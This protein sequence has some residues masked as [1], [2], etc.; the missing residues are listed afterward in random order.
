MAPVRRRIP[1]IAPESGRRR[2]GEPEQNAP[3]GGA[4]PAGRAS[5]GPV[6]R[7]GVGKMTEH[8]PSHSVSTSRTQGRRR[9][10]TNPPHRPAQH[11]DPLVTTRILKRSGC[12]GSGPSAIRVRSIPG[13][14]APHRRVG[15]KAL[16]A[17]HHCGLG[18]LATPMRDP[19]PYPCPKTSLVHFQGKTDQSSRRSDCH[20]NCEVAIGDVMTLPSSSKGHPGDLVCSSSTYNAR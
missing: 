18:A 17:G 16:P 5:A 4:M 15:T 6:G 9:A 2:A 7:D 19:G 12:P 13:R 11:L 10:P 14:T 3:Q 8:K 1:A 20:P